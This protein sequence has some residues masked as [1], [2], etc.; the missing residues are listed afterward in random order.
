M[1]NRTLRALTAAAAVTVVSGAAAV[2]ASAAPTGDWADF[3][4]C[5]T[6]NSLITT[7][8]YSANSS[9]AFQL[10]N[11][12]V[13]INKTIRLRGGIYPDGSAPSGFRFVPPTS[14][15]ALEKV[16]LE[17]P[18]G[19]TGMVTPSAIRNIP[20]LGPIFDAAVN[21]TNG[22]KA[23]AELVGDVQFSVG[24]YVLGAAPAAVLPV[25]IKLDNPFLGSQ[26][27]IGSAS[28]P[29]VLSLRTGTTAPPAPNVPITGDRGTVQLLHAGA[30]MV[31]TGNQL[32]DNAFSVP[33]ASNCGPWGFRWAVTPIVNLKEGF[34]SAAG[35]NS[36]VMGG[37]LKTGAAASVRA[38]AQ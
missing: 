35:N 36:A 27:Y 38:S 20:L 23:T 16:P 34:P 29:V 19:L 28:N 14:V 37:V 5:P 26:C 31:A 11:A 18:G 7:C 9:G 1:K 25:R 6:G 15:P 24:N 4:D 32:V 33:A 17:V 2:G 12:D 13:P 8:V 21:A 30:L 3:K 10:G 22:V